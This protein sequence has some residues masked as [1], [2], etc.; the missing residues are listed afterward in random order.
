M[1]GQTPGTQC[2]SYCA[3]PRVAL[4]SGDNAPLPG[5]ERA[6]ELLCAALDVMRARTAAHAVVGDTGALA[7]FWAQWA[8]ALLT[9]PAAS[10]VSARAAH[11][12]PCAPT[13][14]AAVGPK[15]SRSGLHGPR[16]PWQCTVS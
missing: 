4:P 12:A 8:P 2:T 6:C 1:V 7:E 13:A 3:P 10:A 15:N 11:A 16:R 14:G 5:Q 9:D